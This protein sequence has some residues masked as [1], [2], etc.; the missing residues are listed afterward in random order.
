M[1]SIKTITTEVLRDDPSWVTSVILVAGSAAATLTLNDSDD[2]TGTDIITVKA[3]A[4]DSKPVY[5]GNKGVRFAEGIYSTIAGSGAV[6]YVFH[7]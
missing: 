7:A 2:G 5:I 4:N 1:R 3:L 6:A